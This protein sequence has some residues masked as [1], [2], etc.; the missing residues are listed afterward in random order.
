MIKSDL[1]QLEESIGRDKFFDILRNNGLLVGKKKRFART[2]DSYHRFYVHK[3]LINLIKIDRPNQVYVSDITYIRLAK[4]KFAYL[5]L[6]TDAY[7][8]KI[9][10]WN[11]SESLAI[12]GALK[13]LNMAL[14]Q[15]SDKSRLIHHSDRGIQYC[16]KAYTKLLKQ[17]R[18][19]IS[20]TEKN[21]C[22]ENA[23]AERV[24]GILK[25]E[26]LLNEEFSSYDA[27]LKAVKQAIQSYNNLRPHMS[28]N[29]Q[30]PA[31]VHKAA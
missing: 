29:Y 5:F 2:T 18:V 31:F 19:K 13:A 6:I 23:L 30:T 24:N 10:G 21:H 12:P 16:C 11:L 15:C 3:N 25:D 27:S 14:K 22:Y 28:L 7:S 9:V 17:N 1:E 26:F 8:R 4:S 20:M